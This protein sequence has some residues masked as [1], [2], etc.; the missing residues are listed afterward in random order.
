MYSEVCY[1]IIGNQYLKLFSFYLFYYIL[2]GIYYLVFT[3]TYFTIILR[4]FMS[5]VLYGRHDIQHTALEKSLS[6][7]SFNKY[8]W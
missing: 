2:L 1:N 6:N 7:F 8:I 3:I 5:I 4:L